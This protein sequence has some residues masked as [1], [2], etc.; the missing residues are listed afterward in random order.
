MKAKKRNWSLFKKYTNAQLSEK[1][2]ITEERVRQLRKKYSAETNSAE[3]GKSQKIKKII[4]YI[5]LNKNKIISVKQFKDQTSIYYIDGININADLLQKIANENNLKIKLKNCEPLKKDTHSFER[6]KLKL[7]SCD[8]CKLANAL[9]VRCY[10]NYITVPVTVTDNLAK[11]YINKYKNEN[12][13]RKPKFYI[14]INKKLEKMG[15]IK[16]SKCKTTRYNEKLKCNKRNNL[17]KDNEP[18]NTYINN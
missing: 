8:I 1:W 11:L 9:K 12:S 16:N 6:Y 4:S 13:K 2:K 17:S 7:C 14:F 15:Y 18:C 10:N 3:I 5:K